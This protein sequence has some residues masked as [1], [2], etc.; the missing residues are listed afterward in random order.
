MKVYVVVY[1]DEYGY[2]QP[3][4]NS[5]FSSREKAEEAVEKIKLMLNLERGG[6]YLEIEE[7]EIDREYFN[8]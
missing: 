1:Y 4:M 8:E 7:Y 6:A 3:Q 2:Y 5:A